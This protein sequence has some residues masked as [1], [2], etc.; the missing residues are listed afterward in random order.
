M[1]NARCPALLVGLAQVTLV[2]ATSE[3]TGETDG[4]GI[5]QAGIGRA[6]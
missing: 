3:G 4:P 5:I 6:D 1:Q 2:L